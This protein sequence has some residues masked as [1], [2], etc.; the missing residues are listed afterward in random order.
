M[1]RSLTVLLLAISVT[2]GCEA[3]GADMNRHWSASSV[4]PRM[5]RFFL[6]Y[7]ADKDGPYQE[8]QW[9]R[10][11]D[12]QVTMRRHLL[13]MNP[14]NP[15]HTAYAAQFEPRPNA[16]P[17][18]NPIPY[19]HL[20]GVILGLVGWAA[21][22]G[23]FGS[24]DWIPI[25]V[26]S[27][28]GTMGPGGWNEFGAGIAQTVSPLAVITATFLDANWPGYSASGEPEEVPT[29]TELKEQDGSSSA[30]PVARVTKLGE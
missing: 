24:L 10:K 23:P 6:G 29:I 8:F 5:Q 7:N 25:P 21:G 17:L 9:D 19:V 18:P 28:I 14:G 30:R 2:A 20:E 13:N 12:I 16:S 22:L 15:N 11:M 3:S 4:P 1:N 27:L 26:D